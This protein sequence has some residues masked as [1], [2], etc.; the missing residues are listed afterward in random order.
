MKSSSRAYHPLA[1]SILL[2][3]PA[4]GG[5]LEIRA[6]DLN[7]LVA[8]IEVNVE[9]EIEID[10][11]RFKVIPKAPQS[12]RKAKLI[13]LPHVIFDRATL[14]DVVAFLNAR[15]VEAEGWEKPFNIILAYQPEKDPEVTLDLENI[16]F[17]SVLTEIARQTRTAIFFAD[18]VIEIR[19]SPTED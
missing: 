8:T 18:D 3:W 10:G 1:L 13:K 11:K 7:E 12:E 15:Q 4:Q 6:K 19:A 17:F 9:S 14:T 5:E 2:T 16:S